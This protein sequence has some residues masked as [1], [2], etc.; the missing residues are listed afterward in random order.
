MLRAPSSKFAVAIGLALGLA[1]PA[2]GWGTQAHRV[3]A[4]IANDRLSPAAKA[5]VRELLHEGDTLADIANWADHEG[6]D[7]VPGSVPWHYV[8]VPISAQRYDTSF[9]RRGDCVVEKIKHY[10]KVLADRRSPQR[11]RQR[12]LLFLVHL[13]GD[14]HQPMHVGDNSDRGGN[15]TQV[16]F[17]DR[18]TNLHRLWD[19]DLIHHLRGNDREWAERVKETITPEAVQQWS[20]GRVEDWAD[21]SLAMAKRAYYFPAGSPAPL[22]S[23]ASLGEDYVRMADPI[24][25]EQMGRAG[26]RLANELN[27]IFR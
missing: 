5:A 18:G 27:A 2:L 3:I 22:K 1:P 13:V 26:V 17:V 11:E 19:T 14:I 4:M 10:R 21:E 12:A 16:Q 6:H 7:A 9:C 8:N 15:L 24:L 20:K 25:R 23:G